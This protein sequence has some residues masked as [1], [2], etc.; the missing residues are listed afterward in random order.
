[1]VKVRF[2]QDHFGSSKKSRFDWR[3][4]DK[5]GGNNNDP[6]KIDEGLGQNDET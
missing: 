1:M 6:D 4:G 3:A 2:L 5:L